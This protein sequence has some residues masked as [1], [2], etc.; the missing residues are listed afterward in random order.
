MRIEAGDWCDVDSMA[1]S[2]YVQELD[3]RRGVLTRRFRITDGEGAGRWSS[4]RRLVSMAD[5]FL[6]GLDVTVVAENWAGRLELRS[7]LDGRVPT[8]VW[9]GM[10]T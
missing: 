4:Q 1:V 9:P 7:G 8:P 3:L 5:P 6:A 2:D 10:R